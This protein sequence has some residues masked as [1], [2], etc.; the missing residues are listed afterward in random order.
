M[1]TPREALNN[2]AQIAQDHNATLKP[3]EQ[4]YFVP[5][6]QSDV[7]NVIAALDELDAL[8]KKIAADAVAA[9]LI[10]DAQPATP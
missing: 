5:G 10:A 2:L 9:A 8:K 1:T 6:A 4:R 7:N 3:S